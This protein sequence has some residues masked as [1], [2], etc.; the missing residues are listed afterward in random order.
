M[1]EQTLNAF[2]RLVLAILLMAALA[3]CNR[4]PTLAELEDL[5]IEV[6][7]LMNSGTQQRDIPPSR[8][9]QALQRL[10][11]ER[12]Y[13]NRQGLYIVTSSF[14]AREQGVYVPRDG[15]EMDTNPGSDPSYTWIGLGFY[16]YRIEG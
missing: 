5:S 7:D 10:E 15:A 11:P 2:V 1:A 6:P 12:V 4:T 14:F 3:A 9:P 8:W 16:A 13:A